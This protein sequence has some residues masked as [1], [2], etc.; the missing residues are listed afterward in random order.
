MQVYASYNYRRD[1]TSVVK[2]P[3]RLSRP[4]SLT[5]AEAEE[6]EADVGKGDAGVSLH[7]PTMRQAIGWEL[8]MRNI[9]QNEVCQ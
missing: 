4:R 6:Q 1:L 8:A 3:G 9:R 2:S 7:P 5:L